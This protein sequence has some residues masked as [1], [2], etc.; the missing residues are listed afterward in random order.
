MRRTAARLVNGAIELL[1]AAA[2]GAVRKGVRAGWLYFPFVSEAL[3]SLPFSLGWKLRRAV[4]AHILPH[5][6]RDT[7]LHF[8]VVL[9]DARSSIGENVWI[10]TGCYLDYVEIG[11]AVLI[12]PRAVLLAG[13]R[14]HHFD[15]LDVPI[16]DQG[17]PA[18]EPLR[19]GRGAWIGAN[20][21]VLAEIGHDAI[22]GAGAVVTKPVPPYAI[23]VG[24]PA[25]LL[26]IREAAGGSVTVGAEKN[27]NRFPRAK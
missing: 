26:G 12:G 27:A 19:I 21:T 4:Y 24:N 10:S 14:H 18:K 17:N 8:G 5:V 3:S 22:V 6:G 23:V 9:E 25:R 1:G 7:V 16:K 11:D 20:A 15:R 13:G 2:G